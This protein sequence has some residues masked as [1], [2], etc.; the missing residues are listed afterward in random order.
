MRLAK[1]LEPGPE[2][3][4]LAMCSKARER[5]QTAA[6]SA[7]GTTAQVEKKYYVLFSTF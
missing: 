6:A 1:M 7:Q 3:E 2:L 4:I 5:S